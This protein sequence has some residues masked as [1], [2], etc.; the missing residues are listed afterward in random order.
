MSEVS[1]NDSVE[2]KSDPVQTFWHNFHSDYVFLLPGAIA[3]PQEGDWKKLGIYARRE[4]HIGPP[5][6]YDLEEN[7]GTFDADLLAEGEGT[8]KTTAITVFRHKGY[9]D[10]SDEKRYQVQLFCRFGLDPHVDADRSNRRSGA[11]WYIAHYDARIPKEG[12]VAAACG[13]LPVAGT[14]PDPNPDGSIT[15]GYGYTPRNLESGDLALYISWPNEHDGK[16][17]ASLCPLVPETSIFEGINPEGETP[18]SMLGGLDLTALATKGIIDWSNIGDDLLVPSALLVTHGAAR[19]LTEQYPDGIILQRR[20][21]ALDKGLGRWNVLFEKGPLKDQ[22]CY[23]ETIA[24]HQGDNGKFGE[25][26]YITLEF[27]LN[28]TAIE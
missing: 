20:S 5:L 1:K 28:V 19:F 15:V 24:Q 27:S 25:S 11:E 9:D 12:Q 16:G 23:A 10:A 3:V 6:I 21:I 18:E 14:P 4:T 7:A 22:N 13:S 26:R 8:I 17:V 2:S